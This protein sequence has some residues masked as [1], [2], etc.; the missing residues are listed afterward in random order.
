[1]RGQWKWERAVSLGKRSCV[2]S[3]KD[4]VIVARLS[5]V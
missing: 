1:V 2:D 4:D 3:G 5:R